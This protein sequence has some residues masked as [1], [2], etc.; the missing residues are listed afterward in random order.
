M[1]NKLRNSNIEFLRIIGMFFI[2]SAHMIGYTDVW[3]AKMS[4]NKIIGIALASWSILAVDIFVV[5][6]SYFMSCS[7]D[8]LWLK[9][10]KR[11]VKVISII[12]ETF[13]A[14]LIA[15]CVFMKSISLDLI[16]LAAKTPFSG[17]YWYITAYL[18]LVILSPL[19]DE[20][21]KKRML[22]IVILSILVGLDFIPAHCNA[23]C[24]HNDVL[25]FCMIYLLV[26]TVKC[27]SMLWTK[28]NK[29]TLLIG[30]GIA[31]LF[32]WVMFCTEGIG[33]L[34]HLPY[35]ELTRRYSIVMVICAISVFA[36]TIRQPVRKCTFVNMFADAT[37]AVYIWHAGS[38]WQ[39]TIA[40]KLYIAKL[41]ETPYW[42]IGI[43]PILGG[44]YR[45]GISV[46]DY[47][48]DI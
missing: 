9:W 36:Y 28:F 37:L 14:S 7:K 1:E 47:N 48:M 22:G 40:E 33:G 46:D 19:L 6:F 41:Y 34:I 23:G 11:I 2:I 8:S 26:G 13:V 43:V 21:L 30:A 12:F 42:F 17:E 4:F 38:V 25:Q 10:K 15:R 5:I 31:Q 16:I 20:I 39:E 44:V 35:H 18:S 24:Y 32:Y 45:A 3:K 29:I 27:S